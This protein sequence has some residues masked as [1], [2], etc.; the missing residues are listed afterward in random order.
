MTER[1]ILRSRALAMW[2]G[3]YRCPTTGHVLEQLPGDDKVICGCGRSN[4]RVPAEHTEQTGVH[5]VRSLETAS[6]DAY[7]DQEEER[8]ARR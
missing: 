5:I 3:F 2:G 1:E 8:R 7:L 4:P 6:V